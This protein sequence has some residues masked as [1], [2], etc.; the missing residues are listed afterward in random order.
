METESS[1]DGKKEDF[2]SSDWKKMG[3][4]QEN[5]ILSVL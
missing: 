2:L 3:L 1:S 4:D 5:N